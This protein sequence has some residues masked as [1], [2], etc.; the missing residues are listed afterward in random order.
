MQKDKEARLAAALRQNLLKRKRQE[1]ERDRQMLWSSMQ[2]SG[3]AKGAPPSPDQTAPAV[4]AALRHVA[5]AACTLAIIPMEDLL[6]LQDQPNLPGTL[7]E[8]PNWSRRLPGQADE[9]LDEPV[10]AARLR[11]LRAVRTSPRKA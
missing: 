6:G 11:D 10:V 9:L 7:D 1:R 8:H 5:S 3:A 2:A 4:D